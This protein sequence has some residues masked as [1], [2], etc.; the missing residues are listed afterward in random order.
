[1]CSNDLYL[2]SL[3]F[4]I[5]TIVTVSLA[6]AS[7]TNNPLAYSTS[8]INSTAITTNA[9]L[10]NIETKKVRV[11]DIDIA[12]KIFGKGKPLL[13]IPGFS[14]TMDMWDPNMLNRLSS[15]HTIIVFDNRGIGQTTA[16]NDPKKFSI[17]QFANDTAGFLASLKLDDTSNDILGL[18]LGGF[19]AQ[20]FVL[21]YPDRVDKLILLVSSCGGKESIPP[22]LSPEAFRSMVSGNASKALFLSTLFP[23]E[24]INENIDYIEKN[25]VFPMG[26][27]RTQNLLLQSQAAG[28]WE[29]CDRLSNI[30]NPTL[31]V[32]GTEDITAPP[33]NS[34]MMAE[35]IPGAW[36][37][38]IRGGG[39]GLIFQYPNEFSEILETFFVVS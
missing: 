27:I 8:T 37:V 30:T 35:K 33:A 5:F 2:K 13:L 7:I 4:L 22:Q 20:E 28:N 36:L 1:M 25:F 24:W 29:A 21:T 23:K 3:V 31:V 34:V 12:Y 26:K 18:S 32:T 11:G 9:F 10:D 19:I 16:G 38:Q 15:N 17:S 6:I 39:H 14:M